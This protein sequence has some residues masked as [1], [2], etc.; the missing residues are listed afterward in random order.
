MLTTTLREISQ[1]NPHPDT[2]KKV[3]Q[4]LDAAN[5]TTEQVI[6]GDTLLSAMGPA[7]MLEWMV[8][9]PRTRAKAVRFLVGM[10]QGIDTRGVTHLYTQFL[11][12]VTQA[13]DANP[14]LVEVNTD[15]WPRPAVEVPTRIGG[16]PLR[17]FWLSEILRNLGDVLHPCTTP[18][19]RGRAAYDTVINLVI[20]GYARH[21]SA[22]EH[23]S[24]SLLTLLQSADWQPLEPS[25]A[26]HN[27]P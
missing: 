18:M 10:A 12:R 24:M 15:G 3:R 17:R 4:L 27:L 7:P 23:L 8:Q 14:E 21:T 6:Q 22:V 1:T 2:Y 20:A 13:L 26:D 16:T 5:T 19:L 9:C 25:H 11:A